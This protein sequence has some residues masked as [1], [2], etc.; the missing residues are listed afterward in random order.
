WFQFRGDPPAG[1]EEQPQPIVAPQPPWVPSGVP[2]THGFVGRRDEVAAI[3]DTLHG[4]HVVA[5]VG[6]RAVG[7]TACAVH[8]ANQ[9]R[10]RFPDGQHYLN[11]RSHG[12]PMSARQVTVA[13][14]GALAVPVARRADTNAISLALRAAIGQQHVVVVLDNVDFADQVRALLP[15]PPNCLLLLAGSTR[16][17]TLDGVHLHSLAEPSVPDCVEMF[18]EAAGERACPTVDDPAVVELVE[19][20]GRQPPAARGLGRHLATHGWQPSVFLAE[21]RAELRTGR[22]G[23]EAVTGRSSGRLLAMVAS[24]DEAYL[25]LDRSARRAYRLLALASAPVE[26]QHV[27]ALTGASQRRHKR[28]LTT[29]VE[30][31]F[32]TYTPHDQYVIRPPLEGYAAVHLARQESPRA[33]ARARLRLIDQLVGELERHRP[34]APSEPGRAD[35]QPPAN[36]DEPSTWFDRHAALIRSIIDTP[37][38]HR[39]GHNHWFRLVVAAARCFADRH[40][41]DPWLA[42]CQAVLDSPMLRDNAR[43]AGWAHNQKGVILRRRGEPGAAAAELAEAVRLRTRWGAAQSRTNYGLVLLDQGDTEGALEQLRRARRSRGRRDRRGTALTDVALGAAYLAHGDPRRAREHL[44][45]AAN[46]LDERVDAATHAAALANLGLALWRLNEP[47]DAWQ[48]WDSVRQHHTRIRGADVDG[49]VA[50]LVNVGAALL[51]DAEPRVDEARTMFEHALDL[52]EDT[53]SPTH[54][55]AVLLCLGDAAAAAK[56]R[57]EATTRWQ[58]ARTA[59]EAVG[60]AH[61]AAAAE[62]RLSGVRG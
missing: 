39:A 7:T 18:R 57:Q 26:G 9:V 45:G 13:L 6:R 1:D 15:P 54:R 38:R 10:E 50:T 37:P 44:V 33:Q 49:Q 62:Q 60:D 59:A 53:S 51:T 12:R 21:L 20:C 35:G 5:V 30:E 52:V 55:A 56:D 42:A 47:H 25:A 4:G 36:G 3:V 17:A 14:A 58:Q 40:E 2:L 22:A 11:L 19:L 34:W 23:R 46:A 28:A 24:W 43:F 27:R 31:A 61:S 48:A 16:L 32:V 41:L 29:L 8:A